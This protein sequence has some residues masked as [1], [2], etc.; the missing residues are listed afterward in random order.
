VDETYYRP[1]PGWA[2]NVDYWESFFGLELQLGADGPADATSLVIGGLIRLP[3]R[4]VHLE[5]GYAGSSMGTQ[6]IHA[7]PTFLGSIALRWRH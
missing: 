3:Q 5:F 7:G 4:D 6:D 1:Y 2:L